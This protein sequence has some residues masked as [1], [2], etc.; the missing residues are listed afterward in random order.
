MSRAAPAGVRVLLIGMAAF[1]LPGTVWAQGAADALSGLPVPGP[2]TVNPRAFAAYGALA[3]AVMLTLLYLYRGR[4]FIVYWIGAWLLLAMALGVVTRPY[5]N[6][7]LGSAVAGLSTLFVVW[8]A[9]LMLLGARAF[10]H[11]PMQWS[12]A[13][14]ALSVS[15]LWFLVAPFF[16]PGPIVAASGAAAAA[17]LLGWAGFEYVR[18][19]RVSRHVGGLLVGAG[20]VVICIGTFAGGALLLLDGPPSAIGRMAAMNGAFSLFVAL[21]MHLLVFED[22]TEELRLTNRELADANEQVKRLAITDALTGCN[23]RRFFDEIER[24]EIQRHR[25]Y[26]SP[27]AVV[28]V[29]VNQFK[30][31]NDTLGHDRGD[32]TLRA[33]GQVLRRQ[34]RESDYVI[35]WG[36]DEFVLLLTCTELEGRAKAAELK[37]VFDQERRRAGL[38]DYVGLSIGVVAVPKGADSLRDAIR[39]ADIR[40][41]Q[42]KF[43]ERSA[44][45]RPARS[46]PT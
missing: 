31:L 39:E 42:D 22:M 28:F 5:A 38:P 27:L 14:T 3:C 4:G 16:V 41:Y 26:G 37:L 43:P 34:V 29:D 18:L 40:M 17:G 15:V 25:R 35:R 9:G 12:A 1:G 46:I 8:S 45:L 33:I 11:Q 6:V 20:L 21:G 44:V 13:L 7:L 32:D 36:G 30:R 2:V 19:A 24:R 23:N 10:P